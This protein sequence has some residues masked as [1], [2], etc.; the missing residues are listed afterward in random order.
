MESFVSLLLILL[1]VGGIVGIAYCIFR[2]ILW[3]FFKYAKVYYTKDSGE[4]SFIGYMWQ[5]KGNQYILYDGIP[6]LGANRIGTVRQK[7]NTVYLRTRNSQNNYVENA[8]GTVSDDGEI[9]VNGVLVAV[10]STPN[11]NNTIVQGADKEVA[12]VDGNRKAQKDLIVR[13]GAAG[14]LWQSITSNDIARPDVRIGFLDLALPSAL[15]FLILYIPFSLGAHAF[16]LFPF[17]GKEVSYTLNMLILYYIICWI[18]YAIKHA[19]TM[20]NQSIAFALGLIDRNVGV[21]TLNITILILSVIGVFTCTFITSYTMLPLFL[22]LSIAF[23]SNMKCFDGLWQLEEPCST[24]GRKWSR[25]TSGSMPAPSSSANTVQG[26][27]LVE[28]TFDWGA[29]LEQKGIKHQNEQVTVQLYEEDFQDAQLSGSVRNKNPFKDGINTSEERLNFARTVLKG[30]DEANNKT[31]ESALVQ[32]INS[33]YQICQNYNLA[34]F[35]LYELILLFCQTNI[36]YIPD[37][38]SEP[39]AKSK[40]YFRFPA[41]TLYD[42]EGDCDCKSVLAYRLYDILGVDVNFAMLS[43]GDSNS[44]NHAAIILK[45]TAG[46]IVSLPPTFKEYAPNK[47][48]YCEPTSGGFAPGELPG[49]V[50][51][52]SIITIKKA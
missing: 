43:V 30:S 27:K 40:E 5:R 14:A 2:L 29:I 49:G 12:Y 36:K 19:M 18:L 38:E 47:G 22:V 51:T 34:D 44:P 1:K 42:R 46:A 37:D 24:W 8:Y 35:E 7:D 26:K 33:A 3:F 21:G 23:I 11:E 15:I 17:L 28:C 6:F 41:E 4:R 13:A 45:K 16:A 20:R 9:F 10:C 50:D 32:I 52:D 48:V 25:S 31:E 39:I